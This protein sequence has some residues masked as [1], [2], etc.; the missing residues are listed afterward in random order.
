MK[1]MK[2]TFE[3]DPE[4]KLSADLVFTSLALDQCALNLGSGISTM[5]KKYQEKELIEYKYIDILE[6]IIKK[7]EMISSRL[8][9][10]VGKRGGER[11]V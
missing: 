7:I 8:K 1:P 5:L 6:D 2:D 4:T 3:I 10:E 9:I 11:E